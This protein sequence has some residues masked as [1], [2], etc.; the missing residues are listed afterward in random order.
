MVPAR[1]WVPA[2]VV[3]AAGLLLSLQEPGVAPALQPA[4]AG[5]AAVGFATVAW[6]STVAN[7]GSADRGAAVRGIAA[8][9]IAAQAVVFG[10]W[11][12]ATHRSPF[13]TT[14][15]ETASLVDV[16]PAFADSPVP[17]TGWLVG[18]AVAAALLLVARRHG[19]GSD[20]VV[21]PATLAVATAIVIGIADV[22][23]V[24][25]LG[26]VAPGDGTS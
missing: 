19:G 8:T 11:W 4:L 24:A 6:W 2:G 21:R 16:T 3:V 1:T 13:A 26:D 5:A 18:W 23:L 12:P 14:V 9:A 17:P 15:G 20:P 10:V 22:A 7:I 25:G